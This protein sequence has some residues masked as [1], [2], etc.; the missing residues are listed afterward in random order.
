MYQKSGSK[1]RK[2]AGFPYNEITII[3][4]VFSM[5]CSQSRR[6]FSWAMSIQTSIRGLI[7]V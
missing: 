2:S 6:A 7:D 5:V 4:K 1:H 3:L